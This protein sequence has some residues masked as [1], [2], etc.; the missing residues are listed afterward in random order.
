M[1]GGIYTPAFIVVVRI[2]SGPNAES[3]HS[4]RGGPAVMISCLFVKFCHDLSKFGVRVQTSIAVRNV[5]I[6][7]YRGSGF[8]LVHIGLDRGVFGGVR[9]GSHVNNNHSG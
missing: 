5:V 7:D 2:H 3:G 9:S 4:G 8:H 6:V 1:T